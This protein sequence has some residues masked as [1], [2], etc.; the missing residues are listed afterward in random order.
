MV[1]ENQITPL[2][3][4]IAQW[5]VPPLIEGLGDMHAG[6]EHHMGLYGLLFGLTL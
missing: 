6:Q 4:V 5:K 3:G 1:Y 2:L